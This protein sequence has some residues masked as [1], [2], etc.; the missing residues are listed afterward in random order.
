MMAKREKTGRRY[1]E[2][3][4]HGWWDCGGLLVDDRGPLLWWTRMAV[5]DGFH[6]GSAGG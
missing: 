6:R 4:S 2:A 5:S 3:P 1:P